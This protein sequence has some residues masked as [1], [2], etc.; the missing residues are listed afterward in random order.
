MANSNDKF[1]FFSRQ[2][3]ELPLPEHPME[4]L[5]NWVI[6]FLTSNN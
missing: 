6:H 3:A 4:A 2:G 5:T 1:K